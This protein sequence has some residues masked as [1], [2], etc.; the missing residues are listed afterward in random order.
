MGE[1]INNP[2][3]EK[4]A[5]KSVYFKTFVWM[6]L[7]LLATG[8]ISVFTYYSGFT[9][10]FVDSWPV[11]IILAVVEVVV[12]VLFG[13]LIN[14]LPPTAIKVLFFVYAIINGITLSTIFSIFKLYSIIIVFFASAAIF[15]VCALFGYF[16]KKNLSPIGPVFIATLIIGIIVSIINIFLGNPVIDI[17]ID[18]VVLIVFLGVTA[19]DMQKLK[20]ASQ[21]SGESEDKIAIYCAMELYLDFINIFIRILEIFGDRRD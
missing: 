2:V 18:W 10:N 14:K 6:F 13:V 7:G 17:I 19:W 11:V 20:M 21:H 16:T 3:Q 1:E 9:E 8:I 15:G 12:V 4:V 5:N